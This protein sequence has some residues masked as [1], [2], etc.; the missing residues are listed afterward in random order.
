MDLDAFCKEQRRGLLPVETATLAYTLL[1]AAVI[2]LCWKDMAHPLRLIESRVLVVAG[3]GVLAGIYYLAPSRATRFMRSLYPLTLLG[4]WYPDTYEFCQLLP[5]LD[6]FFAQADLK[7]FGCQPALMFKVW[8]PGKAWSEAFH[9]GYF[10]YYPMIALCAL[11]PLA[12]GRERFQQTAFTLTVCFFFY[13][14]IYL[15]LPV[16]GPQYYFHAVDPELVGRGCFPHLGDYFRHHTELRASTLPDGFFKRLVETAQQ[17]GERPTAA[18]PSSHA[19]MSTV[20]MILVGRMSRRVMLALVPF[21]V[22]LCGATVYIEA[23][24]LV[25]MLG[26]LITGVLFVPLA[27]TLYSRMTRHPALK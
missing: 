7:L 8:L 26:G 19:G 21:Y 1:T 2:A 12:T 15:F 17:S 18:F 4:F 13:Y 16:A 10:A 20:I 9:M 22:L 3:M 25:D 14:T 6:W 27:E 5:N 23:H 11:L 24:Y